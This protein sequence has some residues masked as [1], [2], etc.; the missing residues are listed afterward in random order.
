MINRLIKCM[1]VSKTASYAI[2]LLLGTVEASIEHM[3]QNQV[4]PQPL[5]AV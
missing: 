3:T 2:M 4:S 1:S 5:L